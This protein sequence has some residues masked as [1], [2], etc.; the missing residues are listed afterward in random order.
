MGGGVIAA[1]GGRG[2]LP[3]FIAHL[4]RLAV[5]PQLG[6]KGGLRFAGMVADIGMRFATDA[7]LMGRIR[8]VRQQERVLTL[9]DLI[10]IAR[11]GGE[12]FQVVILQYI[13]LALGNLDGLARLELC[14]FAHADAAC[15]AGQRPIDGDNSV[16]AA[17]IDVAGCTVTALRIAGNLH[18][19]G[20]GHSAADTHTTTV[21]CIV[22]VAAVAGDVA[23]VHIESAAI[24]IVHAAAE[25]GRVAAD[26]AVVHVEGALAVAVV[27]AVH[28]T[29]IVRSAIVGDLA[30]VQIE[31]ALARH[32][33]AATAVAGIIA[34]D[35]AAVHGESTAGQL[36]AVALIARSVG[37]L[38]ILVIVAVALAVHQREGAA[39][40]NDTS[41]ALHRDAVAVQAERDV[42]IR[43]PSFGQLH[44]L[45]QIIACR[46]IY[47][48][49]VSRSTARTVPFL[50]QC[51]RPLREL[52]LRVLR[53][54]AGMARAAEIV[55]MLF[56]AAALTRARVRQRRC[57]QQHQSQ[58]QDH[59]P[60]QQ[61]FLHRSPPSVFPC[62]GLSPAGRGHPVGGS[63]TG[64]RAP[65]DGFYELSRL[66]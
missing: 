25:S 23:A 50:C 11:V 21:V 44:V 4:Q 43:L 12:G 3:L 22:A 65:P 24:A 46:S 42:S 20:D 61:T 15:A 31:G 57:G 51:V 5:H 28:A 6:G 32:G 30:A 52:A 55:L 62:P 10:G 58:G 2:R 36:H 26:L 49:G 38:A 13:V 29:A 41:V 18:I 14:R 64:P 35:I 17:Q 60:A 16:A 37:D 19:A 63:P 54:S 48:Q 33:H 27:I 47:R 8:R 1:D 39:G 9:L 66:L 56:A 34:G 59:E 40:R 45:S 7:V 53:I